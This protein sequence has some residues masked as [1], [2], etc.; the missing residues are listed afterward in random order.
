[1]CPN[2]R[3]NLNEN[4][5]QLKENKTLKGLVSLEKLFDR[6]DGYIGNRNAPSSNESGDYDKVNIGDEANPKFINLGKYCTPREKRGFI[7]LLLSYKDVL[8]WSYDDLKNFREGQFQHHIPLKPGATPFRPK[9]R[10]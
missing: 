6:H 10:N 2:P 7:N 3:D 4:I 9:L 8:P 5:I 1:M